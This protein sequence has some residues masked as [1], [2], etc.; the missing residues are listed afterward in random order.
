[1]LGSSLSRGKTESQWT[2]AVDRIFEELVDNAY[3]SSED[4]PPPSCLHRSDIVGLLDQ[5]AKHTHVHVE[6]TTIEDAVDTLFEDAHKEDGHGKGGESGDCDLLSKEQFR[7]LFIAHPDLLRCVQG[8][9]Q[10]H[11]ANSTKTATSGHGEGRG[12]RSKLQYKSQASSTTAIFTPL[13]VYETSTEWKNNGAARIWSSLYFLANIA[14]FSC[15]AYAY[16]N[17]PEATNVFGNCVVVAR[18]SAQCL[19][20][21]CALILLP[22]CR[23]VLTRFRGANKYMRYIFPFDS[24]LNYHIC[25]GLA[26]LFFTCLHVVGQLCIMHRFGYAS[27]QALIK[28]FGNKLGDDIPSSVGERWKLLMHS[29]AVITG[30]IM[31][32]VDRSIAVRGVGLAWLR[33]LS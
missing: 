13:S 1:M 23:Q 6:L 19:N 30:I 26:I 18:G 22:V 5:A 32:S 29:R 2:D 24:A 33:S 3:E 11:H 7:N 27:E 25:I 17:R 16:V 20:L 9:H 31:V 10:R 4:Q 14:V 28:L 8:E 21:N 12:V 15:K